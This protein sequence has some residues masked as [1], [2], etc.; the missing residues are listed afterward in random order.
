MYSYREP[1]QDSDVKLDVFDIL[2]AIQ[3]GVLSVFRQRGELYELWDEL[4]DE[5][6]HEGFISYLKNRQLP[7]PGDDAIQAWTYAY[8]CGRSAALVWMRRQ[9]RERQ[10]LRDYNPNNIEHSDLPMQLKRQLFDALL[11]ERKKKGTRGKMA[12]ARD[13]AIISL[14]VQGYSDEGIAQE[15]GLSVNS[16]PTLRRRARARLRKHFNK[17]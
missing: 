12:A 13:V 15:L 14:A 6:V 16:I 4:R 3:L 17:E 7:K 9:S 2:S 1:P 8:R 5:L 11:A 10:A